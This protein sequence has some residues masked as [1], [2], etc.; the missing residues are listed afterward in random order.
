MR[1]GGGALFA[2]VFPT[3]LARGLPGE[4]RTPESSWEIRHG[5][6]RGIIYG[7]KGEI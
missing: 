6:I 2:D 3:G 1:D 4:V 7:V 5:T